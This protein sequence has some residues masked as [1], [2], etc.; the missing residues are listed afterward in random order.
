MSRQYSLVQIF[1][2]ETYK[3]VS[4]SFSFFEIRHVGELEVIFNSTVIDGKLYSVIQKD[5]LTF[6]TS[7]FPEL[8]MVYE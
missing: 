6:V 3:E 8:Y 4:C 1:I 2:M 7:I 5:G